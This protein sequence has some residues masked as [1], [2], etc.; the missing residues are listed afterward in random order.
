MSATSFTAESATYLPNAE[1]RRQLM[2]VKE[3]LAS[4]VSA[5]SGQGLQES[6]DRNIDGISREQDFP[7]ATITVSGSEPHPLTRELADALVTVA[8]QLSRGRAVLIAPCDTE[9]TTQA[10]ADMLGVSRPTLV[11]LLESGD[12]PF[13]KVGRHRRV[14]MSDL[15][16]Y[17]KKRHVATLQGLD[18]LAG[19]TDPRQT[20]DNPLVDKD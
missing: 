7:T 12:I 14:L 9:L 2:D 5:D 8:D 16:D 15:S 13:T 3:T 1:D 10:A 4:F 19:D 11:K 18:D 20:L 6:V 17:A